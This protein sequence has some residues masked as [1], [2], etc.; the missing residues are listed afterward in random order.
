MDPN[1]EKGKNVLSAM[2]ID[3]IGEIL[4]ISM[5]AA[6]TALSSM[7]DKQV[8]ITTPKVTVSEV[9]KLDYSQLEPAMLVKITYEKG[10]SGSNVMVFRQKDMQYILNQLMGMDGP[11]RD[12]YV[13][14][15]LSISAACEVMNQM[16]GSSS[17]ALAEFLGRSIAISTPTAFIMEGDNTFREA[18]GTGDD[19]NI[20]VIFF[21]LSI[22]DAVLSEFVCVMKIDL[23]RAIVNQFVQEEEE[24]EAPQQPVQDSRQ[25]DPTVASEG[26][27]EQPQ[28]EPVAGGEEDQPPAQPEHET[29]STDIRMQEQTQQD[30][31]AALTESHAQPDPVADPEKE[32]VVPQPEP[33][34]T[35][36]EKQPLP[37][38]E[39]APAGK[40]SQ[41]QPEFA[42]KAAES[43]TQPQPGYAAF[44]SGSNAQPQPTGPG[45][46]P[47][48]NPYGQ[49]Y[50]QQIPGYPPQYQG[51][52][53]IPYQQGG[54][55]PPQMQYPYQYPQQHPYPGYP[56]QAVPQ[57]SQPALPDPKNPAG[58]H[59][60]PEVKEN[61]VIK[62]AVNVRNV[63]FPSFSDKQQ[64]MF[65]EPLTSGNIDMLMNIPL[66]VSI[67][68][69]RT[70]KKIREI[71]DFNQGSIIELEKQ[72]GAPVDVIVNGQ[73][74][75]RGD[76]VVIDDNF[77]VR[78]TEI[79]GTKDIIGSTDGNV[80]KV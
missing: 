15:D 26:S 23:A 67:E 19:E 4:N 16:M 69:G 8:L 46:L 66:N 64:P 79:V 11:L 20:V 45:E 52:P 50:T 40:K 1:T 68:I 30:T 34:T 78:I 43:H 22:A 38:A 74:M 14:D 6:A 12:D 9:G 44:P 17:T 2:E 47:S 37:E 7:L 29:P 75:A 5:G 76:V 27:G 55:Y 57:Y 63:Q 71:M 60:G 58:Q 42:G 41:P 13:F 35:M 59:Q 28:P 33:V 53:G 49:G 54:Q 80:G 24:P 3:A 62:Q 31:S 61:A 48:Y 56:P 32:P 51:Y 73:L 70:K 18:V 21:D 25:P 65:S 10:I 77:A 36:A 72:A 39:T